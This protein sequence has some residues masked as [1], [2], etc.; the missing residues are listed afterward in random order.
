MESRTRRASGV[1]S[2]TTWL[3]GRG[4]GIAAVLGVALLFVGS[5]AASPL[6]VPKY[7]TTD[8]APYS[9]T[10]AGFV[11]LETAGCGTT[12][13]VPVLPSFNLTTG[14]ATESV[15]ETAR[16]CGSHNGSAEVEAEAEFLTASFAVTTGL[17]RITINWV[18]NFS[19]KLA[20]TKGS[21]GTQTAEAGFAGFENAEL[22]D[23]TNGSAV[24]AS[25]V[26]EITNYIQ[27]G[28][29]TH[30]YP[31]LHE[32]SYINATLSSTHSYELIVDVTASVFVFVTP[33]ASSASA[34]MNLGSAGREA[35]L[36]S[37][38][39]K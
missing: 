3:I 39:I 36:A 9:G 31:R 13:A 10:E 7:A 15:Q 26:P 8:K 5:A 29:Y 22:V 38:L 21:S 16:S 11:F 28:S 23:L 14:Y 32:T 6:S 33:G 2:R 19:V 20:A 18:E 27:S 24:Q 35:Q 37:I 34:S 30:V 17:H 25:N 4:L 1:G 12:S